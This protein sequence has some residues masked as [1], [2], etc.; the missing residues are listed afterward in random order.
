[1]IRRL[2]TTIETLVIGQSLSTN[3]AF[4]AMNCCAKLPLCTAAYRIGYRV[5]AYSAVTR[6]LLLIDNIS[7]VVLIIASPSRRCII[8]LLRHSPPSDL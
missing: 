1:M 7:R 8:S 5:V 3:Y 6:K 2:A 4:K